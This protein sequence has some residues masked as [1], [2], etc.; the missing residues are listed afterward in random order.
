MG[1]LVSSDRFAT[2][3]VKKFAFTAYQQDG[4]LIITFERI[5]YLSKGV[6][7]AGR[8]IQTPV[9]EPTGPNN[10]AGPNRPPA[11]AEQNLIIYAVCEARLAMPPSI[12]PTQHVW[13]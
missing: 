10:D 3:L 13:A 9:H 11:A 8:K 12:I 5:R 6:S 1:P 4:M 7:S 2:P